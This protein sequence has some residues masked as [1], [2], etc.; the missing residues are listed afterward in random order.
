ML[1]NTYTSIKI[2]ISERIIVFEERYFVSLERK[3]GVPL[4]V[5]DVKTN[6]SRTFHINTHKHACV[7]AYVCRRI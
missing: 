6:F 1:N 5:S 4:L 3:K 7:C 2:A